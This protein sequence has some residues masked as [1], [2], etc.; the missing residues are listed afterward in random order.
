M[1]YPM[2][3]AFVLQSYSVMYQTITTVSLKY[4]IYLLLLYITNYCIVHKSVYNL[5]C[6]CANK[7]EVYYKKNISRKI[8]F[9]GYFK[10][11]YA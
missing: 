3:T 11:F 10:V 2:Q 1:S 4:I 5:I 6:K 7:K 8:D 9:N